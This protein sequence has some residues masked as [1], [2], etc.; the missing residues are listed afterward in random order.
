MATRYNNPPGND[1][2]PTD[3]P[4]LM[5][6]VATALLGEPTSSTGDKWRYGKRGSLAVDVAAGTFYDHEAGSGGGVIELVGRCIK[7]DRAGALDWLRRGG[8]LPEGRQSASERRSP[9]PTSSPPPA[10][11]RPRQAAS[12][13]FA[14]EIWESAGREERSAA[15]IAAFC[16]YFDR[17]LCWPTFEGAPRLP[18]CVRW[19]AAGGRV[20]MPPE[21]VGCLVWGFR[22]PQG[23]LAAVQLEA[24]SAA[25]R[26]L[27]DWPNAPGAKRKTHGPIGTA[28]LQVGT[29]TKTLV[30]CEGPTDALAAWWL[31]PGAAV[32]C[33]GGTL[34]LKRDDLAG[35]VETVRIEADADAT[36]KA[37]SLG[38]ALQADDLRVSVMERQRGD[39]ADALAERIREAVAERAAIRES[40][41]EMPR[42]EAEDA[43]IQD[44]W[45]PYIT[46]RK[47]PE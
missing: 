7:C 18:A 12:T 5:P 20:A 45:R 38:I 36:S 11:E 16:A 35:V 17:R 10:T 19:L 13:A 34:R 26:C 21:A 43:A 4:A 15:A 22:T 6:A 28:W 31:H 24:L 14:G 25:G 3:W 37:D 42:P 33:C 9:P 32:W 39:V 46:P 27:D 1:Q 8:F 23:Q 41:G 44:A 40:D 30:L 47:E 29:P 2:Q